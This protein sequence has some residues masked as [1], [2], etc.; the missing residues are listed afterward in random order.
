M[1]AIF[2][3]RI[4]KFLYE[5]PRCGARDVLPEGTQQPSHSVESC[6]K[7]L[8][9]RIDDLSEMLGNLQNKT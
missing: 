2:M 5:C 7:Y 6:I 1:S 3:N 9:R 4:S 8:A